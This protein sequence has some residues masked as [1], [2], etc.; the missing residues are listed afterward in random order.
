MLLNVFLF[1]GVIW[2]L[3]QIIK[4]IKYFLKNL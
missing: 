1:V 2:V 4:D 3:I